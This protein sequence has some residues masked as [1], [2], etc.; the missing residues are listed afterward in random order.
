[1]SGKHDRIERLLDEAVRE[2]RD[3]KADPVLAKEAA[4]RVWMTLSRRD[5]DHSQPVEL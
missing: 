2:I 1:M 5:P 3:R 4:D